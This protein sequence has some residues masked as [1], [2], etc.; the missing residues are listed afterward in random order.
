MM[1]TSKKMTTKTIKYVLLA[2]LAV[3]IQACGPVTPATETPLVREEA[4]VQLVM[5]ACGNWA[6]YS[7]VDGS[8]ILTCDS[9]RNNGLIMGAIAT[10]LLPSPAAVYEDTS[11]A[12]SAVI[13]DCLRSDP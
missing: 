9:S 7:C 5:G 2:F 1:T 10:P 6:Q 8:V 13:H 4:L 12:W 11:I 3:L